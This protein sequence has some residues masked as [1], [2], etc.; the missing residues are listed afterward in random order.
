MVGTNNHWLS[1]FGDAVRGLFGS[2]RRRVIVI[3]FDA[4]LRL[5]VTGLATL[6]KEVSLIKTETDLTVETKSPP[7]VSILYSAKPDVVVLE[8]A[9]V[10]AASCVL[11]ATTDDELNLRLCRE[12]RER[13]GVPLTITRL[14]L[15]Q[16]I[17]NWA[18]LTDAGLAR[19]TW[20]DTVR[21]VLVGTQANSALT[22]LASM[23]DREQIVDL[24]MLSPVFI[25]RRI[26]DLPLRECEVAAVTRD[27]V[28]LAALDSVELRL[29]DVLTLVGERGAVGQV[30]ESLTSL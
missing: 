7:G 30:R 15:V 11:A 19:M 3:G 13:F 26:A 21:M 29:G 16:G 1:R 8:R 4:R 28:L 24:E 2:T 9:G 10:E 25:G 27:D 6:G 18:R 20:G 17:T 23:S 5:L 22:Q 12:A 14:K